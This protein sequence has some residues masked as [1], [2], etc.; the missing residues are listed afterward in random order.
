MKLMIS[1]WKSLSMP[2]N[3]DL[4]EL[5][6]SVPNT[7]VVD[8]VDA[9]E[10]I[11]AEYS[12]H[13]DQLQRGQPTEQRTQSLSEAFLEAFKDKIE[14]NEVAFINFADMNV[15]ELAEAF[16]AYPIIIKPTLA[17]VNVAKRAIQRDLGFDFDTYASKVSKEQCMY[18]AGYIKTLLPERIAVPALME[19][20][21]YFWTDKQ[22]RAQKGG[23][24]KKVTQAVNVAS[25]LE[26]RKRMFECEAERFEIDA[27]YPASG[28]RIDV[29]ID[30]KRI[31]SPKDIHKRADEIARKASKFKKTY[32]KGIFYAVVYY[33]FPNQHINLQSRLRDDDID[34]LFFAG[35]TLSSIESA[36]ILI[37]GTIQKK[38]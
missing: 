36:A 12:N 26:F 17:C 7:S 21:R 34:G 20:D 10:E 23:W 29:A 6:A 37:A 25:E 28:A 1:N 9:E 13:K 5:S 3:D 35:E 30:V 16:L 2:K 4:Q 27:A 11:E 24:E 18:L 14:W 33:P 31:E 15:Q 22:M 32:P 38:K 8:E 19:L